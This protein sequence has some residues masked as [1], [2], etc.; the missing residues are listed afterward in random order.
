MQN[1]NSNTGYTKRNKNYNNRRKPGGRAGF[2]FAG[3]KSGGF[4]GK[5]RSRRTSTSSRAK[6]NGGGDKLSGLLILLVVFAI[7][8]AGGRDMAAGLWNSV[9]DAMSGAWNGLQSAQTEYSEQ[10]PSFDEK[11]PGRLEVH[12]MDVGQGDATLV[13]CDGH[14]LL[15]DAGDNS[16]G[17]AVQNYLRKQGV[18]HLDY[19]IGTHP[20]ADHIG[21]LDVVIT[22]FP[23][24]TVMMPELEKDNNTYR[25]VMEALSYQN[26]EKTVPQPGDS[27]MLGR[28]CFTVIAPLKEYR[29]ANNNSISIVLQNGQNR[30][31]FT[32]DA[33]EEAETDILESGALIKADV[34]QA[35]HHGSSTSNSEEFLRA[36]SPEY[37]VISC[38]KDN[39]YGHPHAQSMNL[40]REMG[41]KVYRTDLQGSII[42]YSDGTQI[43]WN[44]SP[45]ESWKSGEKRKQAD[46]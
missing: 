38:G 31:L 34:F 3:K 39:D 30:F 4:S 29:D 43:V 13:L 37:V 20:D 1:R 23:C 33:E 17:T 28:A 41:S 9:T 16:K 18:K 44:C 19:V 10:Q 45:D 40:F 32:G 14:A 15:I 42:A 6:R 8:V 5:R 24:D 11:N 22:K 25:D 12:Y 7:C 2:S 27:F 35:G 46:E 21:G 26:M 36:V